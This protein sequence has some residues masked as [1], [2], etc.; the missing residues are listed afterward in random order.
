M[1]NFAVDRQ[2][3][4]S[5]VPG[6]TAL[7]QHEETT[8]LSLVA[9]RFADTRVLGVSVPLHRS[10]EEVNLRFY[11]RRQTAD[12]FRRGVVFVR[13]L[14]PRRA[15]AA[16][17]R[18]IYNEPYHAVAMRHRIEGTPPGV[19][20]AWRLGGSWQTLSAQAVGAA[21]VPPAGSHAAFITEHYWGYTRQRDGSTLEYRVEHPPWRV[22]EAVLRTLPGG[23]DEL[24]GPEIA[25]TL[26]RPVSVFV[27][28]GSAVSV[29]RGQRMMTGALGHD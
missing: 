28:E 20:Y 11:V 7:D 22:W 2:L 29:F 26:D 8:Y 16:V 27:A 13:E 23:L 12:G 10:F 4:T 18:T 17:A 15:I 3:L 1:V 21:E 5:R 19:S 25:R 6:G 9:F 14:V 24:Y